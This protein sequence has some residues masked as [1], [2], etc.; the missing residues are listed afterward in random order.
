VQALAQGLTGHT[1]LPPV[2]VVASTL[3]IAALFSPLRRRIQAFIDQ[4]FYRRKYDAAR[5]VAQ[6]SARLRS[7]VDLAQL[8]EQLVTVV[9]ET[10]QPAHVSLWL[11][12]SPRSLL[13][14]PGAV[15]TR[16][17]DRHSA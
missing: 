17:A 14:P 4:R 8:N 3:L 1:T 5:I 7:E 15:V 9:R 12:R 10:M 2:A 11:S 13:E 6:F 16:D